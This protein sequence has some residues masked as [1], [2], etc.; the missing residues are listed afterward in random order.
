MK[1]IFADR[2]IAAGALQYQSLLARRPLDLPA[3]PLNVF[4][5]SC[6]HGLSAGEDFLRLCDLQMQQ[7]PAAWKQKIKPSSN[8]KKNEG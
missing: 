1:L 3:A 7:L 8:P 2:K 6:R 4:R 5:C